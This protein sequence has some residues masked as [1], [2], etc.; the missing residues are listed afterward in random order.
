MCGVDEN[1]KRG[2]VIGWGVAAIMLGF[3]FFL[4]GPYWGIVFLAGGIVIV[5]HGHF[6]KLFISRRAKIVTASLFLLVAAATFAVSPL[7]ENLWRGNKTGGPSQQSDA[8]KVDG[9]QQAQTQESTKQ[10]QV[11]GG[12][13]AQK[14]PQ[15]NIHIDQKGNGNTANPGTNTGPIKQGDCSV[16]QNGGSNNSANPC[17]SYEYHLDADKLAAFT[18]F[19][20]ERPKGIVLVRA[21]KMANVDQFAGQVYKAFQ[22][23]GWTMKTDKVDEFTWIASGLTSPEIEVKERGASVQNQVVTFPD[24]SPTFSVLKAFVPLGFEP[25]FSR[26]PALEEGVIIIS[27]TGQ[28]PKQPPQ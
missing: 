10:Q 6:P 20:R 24:N 21:D 18:D 13:K 22:S 5:L 3:S 15:T 9:Q 27:L 8:K 14:Q 2:I 25:K 16:V 4:G 11:A 23:A 12:S 19:L 1:T 26:D 28:F 17:S 7:G